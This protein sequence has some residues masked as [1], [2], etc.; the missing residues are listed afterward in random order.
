MVHHSKAEVLKSLSRIESFF[1]PGCLADKRNEIIRLREAG[2]TMLF[3]GGVKWSVTLP[4]YDKKLRGES[5]SLDNAFGDMAACLVFLA[6]NH[7]DG[8]QVLCAIE[9]ADN[10]SGKDKT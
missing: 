5:E 10:E 9:L 6:K 4:D 2:D 1:I 3:E 7:N 8:A